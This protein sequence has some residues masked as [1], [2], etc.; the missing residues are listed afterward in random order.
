MRRKTLVLDASR[1]RE[2]LLSGGVYERVS[3]FRAKSKLRCMAKRRE[4][5]KDS[6]TICGREYGRVL[7]SRS[8]IVLGE[9]ARIFAWTTSAFSPN[10]QALPVLDVVAL[11]SS[12]V[13]LGIRS[14]L[15][16]VSLGVRLGTTGSE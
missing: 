12:L 8:G 2:N 13:P 10:L 15:E 9:S 4:I 11:S 6:R 16:V 3:R 14:V 5:F 7:D 1:W